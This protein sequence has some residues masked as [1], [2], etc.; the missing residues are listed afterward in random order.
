M[1]TVYCGY[2]RKDLKESFFFPTKEC[3]KNLWDYFKIGIPATAMFSLEFWSNE[4]Q[5][6]LA[7]LIG[8]I[9]GGSMFIMV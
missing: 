6:I 2:Y 1:V 3:Y 5:I 7:N 4:I 9:E 8:P